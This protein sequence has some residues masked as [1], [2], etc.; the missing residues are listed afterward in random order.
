MH[1]TFEARSIELPPRL[2]D[3]LNGFR[4][5]ARQ[6]CLIRLVRIGVAA[7]LSATVLMFAL[8][9]FFDSSQILR[10]AICACVATTL[11]ISIAGVVR[12]F[13]STLTP[14]TTAR[15]MRNRGVAIGDE[16]LGA[17]ELADNGD[18]HAS[19]AL[20]KA[21]LNQVSERVEPEKL[22]PALPASQT[23]G[24]NGWL[25]CTI[26]VFVAVLLLDVKV[27]MNSA[28]RWLV[29]WQDTSRVTMTRV[30]ELPRSIIVPLGEASDF[31]V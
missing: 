24:L 19:K 11:I 18:A 31:E 4:R 2:R 30:Q 26:V 29:P 5:L 15:W 9:R 10:G 22:R 16:I 1:E 23:S 12:V 28:R 27:L 7:A 3:E 21:A 20:R 8:D 13:N 14:L 17:L 6:R 25:L